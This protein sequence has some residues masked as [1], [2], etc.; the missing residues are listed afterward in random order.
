MAYQYALEMPLCLDHESQMG[1]PVCH[2]VCLTF[3]K[4]CQMESDINGSAFCPKD[5]SS[6]QCEMGPLHTTKAVEINNDGSNSEARNKFLRRNVPQMVMG[7]SMGFGIPLSTRWLNPPWNDGIQG[8]PYPDV[9]CNGRKCQNVTVTERFFCF[10]RLF[11]V[12]VPCKADEFDPVEDLCMIV[13]LEDPGCTTKD[14]VN[15]FRM[16]MQSSSGP[17]WECMDSQGH[18]KLC[19]AFQSGKDHFAVVEFTSMAM[20]GGEMNQYCQ[21]AWDKCCQY[22]YDKWPSK[23]TNADDLAFKLF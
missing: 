19:G 15:Q 12:E 17:Y 16:Q 9:F 1:R 20:S 13:K 22:N 18:L 21:G 11:G 2:S 4:D 6:R 10:N 7:S 3:A 5:G 14:C 8:I 23:P